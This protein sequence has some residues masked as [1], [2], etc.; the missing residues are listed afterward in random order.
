MKTIKTL[1]LV[2]GLIFSTAKAFADTEETPYGFYEGE[3]VY[4]LADSVNLREQASTSSK[5]LSLISIGT[6]ARIIEVS[7]VQQNLNG[8]TMNWYLIEVA[9]KKRGYVWGGKLARESFRSNKNTD[10]VFHFG[11]E[12]V[13]DDKAYYQIRV[14]KNHKE[15]QRMTLEGFGAV[16]KQIDITNRAS[17]GLSNVDDIICMEGSGEFCGDDAGTEVLF[18]SGEKLWHVRRLSR[19][20]DVPVFAIQEFIFPCDMDGVKGKIVFR[21]E[22]GEHIFPEDNPN[23]KEPTIEYEKNETT[24]YVW[25]GKKLVKK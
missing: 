12:K 10:F 8:F 1:L 19:F 23:I 25:D 15:I 20:S 7:D 9:P 3:E 14:E 16:N 21:E 24:Y 6:K 17:C 22:I 11:L 5:T 4:V 18:F 13:V 2:S